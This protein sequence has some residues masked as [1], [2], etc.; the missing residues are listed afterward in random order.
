MSFRAV[1]VVA[2][3]LCASTAWGQ[4]APACDSCG[5]CTDRLATDHARA[6]LTAD[7]DAAGVSPCIVLRGDQAEL[8]GRGHILRA[9]D[10]GVRV[11]GRGAQVRNLQVAG[12]HTA[13]V[14]ASPS[15]ATLYHVTAAA[16]DTGI[17][18]M[19]SADARIVRAEV[20]GGHVGVGF[21]QT[22]E[23]RC[24]PGLT[25]QS[26]GAAVLRT[27]VTGA[28]IGIASCD[29]LAVM[30]G[31]RVTDN[32]V[33]IVLG[34]PAAGVRGPGAE[35]PY[36]HCVCAP[37]LDGVHAGTTLLWSSGCGG[38]EVHEAWLPGL[39]A[40]GADIRLRETGGGTAD[41]QR[42]YD[43]YT[44]HCAPEITDVVGIPGS[45]PNYGCMA[46]GQS[47]KVRINDTNW[48]PEATIVD[49]SDVARFAA[50]CASA[51]AR[52][53]G[54]RTCVREMLWD[55][56]VCGNHSADIR[57]MEGAERWSGDDACDTVEGWREGGGQGCTRR[58]GEDAGRG[59][60]AVR[61][62]LDPRVGTVATRTAKVSAVEE[63]WRPWVLLA[64]VTALFGL[65]AWGIGRFERR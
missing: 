33:G 3:L 41:A 42:R 22:L 2:V 39:R 65:G 23:G 32:G 50:T 56:T 52:R 48:I 36:D 46:D 51:A 47:F 61:G 4:F 17:A 12:A 63:T 20:H 5:S 19:A 53:Y 29:A 54:G 15:G 18:V 57:A 13:F 28:E 10:L 37:M 58:C 60:E 55:N 45:V 44:R 9:G 25:M 16:R 6:E 59:V 62:R 8:N 31:N 11:E 7:L 64:V 27:R 40:H 1:V 38:C 34:S 24:A 30:V 26:P 21:G 43:D 35:V 49:A 14:I